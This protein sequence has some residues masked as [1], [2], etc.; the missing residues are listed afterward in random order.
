[1]RAVLEEIDEGFVALDWEY[2]YTH[3]NDAMLRLIGRPRD[4]VIGAVIWELFPELLDTPVQPHCRT[5]MELGEPT[6]CHRAPL[7][8]ER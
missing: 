3:L 7:A 5:A 1:M 2:R 8:V 4:E 6:F